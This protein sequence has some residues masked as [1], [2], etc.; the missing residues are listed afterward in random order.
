VLFKNPRDASAISHLAKQMFPGEPKFLPAAY[1]DATKDPHSY[2][3]I[4]LRQ[5]T[6][7]TM[8]LRT[9]ILPHEWPT[10]TYVKPE[11][12]EEEIQKGG[13]NLHQIPATLRHKH[14]N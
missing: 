14:Y 4:D 6:L 3:F 7:D 12:V 8:R 2:L 13:L 9:R 5:E 10:F 1:A 11:V